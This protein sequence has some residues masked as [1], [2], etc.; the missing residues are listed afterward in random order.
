MNIECAVQVYGNAGS[1]SDNAYNYRFAITTLAYCVSL[2]S[3]SLK[4]NIIHNWGK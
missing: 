1:V 3:H 4:Q 2:S